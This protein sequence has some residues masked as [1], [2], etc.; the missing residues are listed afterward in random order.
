MRGFIRPASPETGD[1]DHI[2]AVLT[3]GQAVV[4]VPT[5][6][7]RA[8]FIALKQRSVRLHGD[9][10]LVL[11]VYCHLR[12]GGQ[13]DVHLADKGGYTGSQAALDNDGLPRSQCIRC[14]LQGIS[15]TELFINASPHPDPGYGIQEVLRKVYHLGLEPV[16]D[17][18]DIVAVLRLFQLLART[19]AFAGY[20]KPG[21]GNSRSLRTAYHFA[22]VCRF[23]T[24]PAIHIVAVRSKPKAA[25][26]RAIDPSGISVVIHI[27]PLPCQTRVI[28]GLQV[29]RYRR[30]DGV[31]GQR[32]IGAQLYLAGGKAHAG[33]EPVGAE[34]ILRA[35]RRIDAVLL[36]IDAV[37]H[38]AAQRL[39]GS[40]HAPIPVADNLLT[41][42]VHYLDGTVPYDI[43]M[44]RDPGIP[45]AAIG[46]E[47]RSIVDGVLDSLPLEARGDSDRDV[48]GAGVP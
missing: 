40:P 29:G 48:Y 31:A 6:D 28:L 4:V 22:I 33:V 38:A 36:R 2:S 39:A 26:R 44:R 30:G 1:R 24:Q 47:L 41:G 43:V 34:G 25:A 7:I 12:R 3:V 20:D 32:R 37:G 19:A 45:Q 23:H 11:V 16:A 8:Q 13:A 46:V 21:L 27:V 35:V 42:G 10:R 14:N 17:I 9:Q 5:T 18:G 15:H